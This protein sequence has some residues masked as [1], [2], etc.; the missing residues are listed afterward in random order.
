MK[1]IALLLAIGF[2]QVVTSQNKEY[3]VKKS[4]INSNQ[5]NFGV[6]FCSDDFVIYTTSDKENKRRVDTDFYLGY[7]DDD[8]NIKNSKKLSDNVNSK[9]SE[10]DVVFSRDFKTVYFTRKTSYRRSKPHYKL[11]KADVVTPGYWINIRPLW[12]NGDKYS[13]AHPCLSND[14]KTLYFASDMPGGYG[15]LD[16]YKSIIYDDGKLG[17]PKN[18]GKRFNTIVDD[19]T[20]FVDENN[21][22]YYASNGRSGYGGF[23]IYKVNLNDKSIP[24]NVGKPINSAKDDYY[25][26]ERYNDNCGHFVSNRESKK[27]AN[28]IYYFEITNKEKLKKLHAIPFTEEERKEAYNRN[29]LSK[30]SKLSNK[31]QDKAT[32]AKRRKEL[33]GY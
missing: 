21:V 20:P 32:L 13:V 29:Q 19:T 26:V 33:L 4:N 7:L 31:K 11:F 28:D 23:D 1:K 18:L 6:A 9:F 30:N 12:F 5:S 10:I 25:Y 22:L 8:G 27:G 2:L 3:R 14:G 16:L 17:K 15:G 24:E